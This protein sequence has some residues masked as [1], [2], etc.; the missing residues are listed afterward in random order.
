M[1]IDPVRQVFEWG[2]PEFKVLVPEFRFRIIEEAIKGEGPGIIHTLV[3]AFDVEEDNKFVERLKSL[4][5]NAGGEMLFVELQANIEVRKRRHISENRAKHKPLNVIQDDS[6][7]DAL[8]K[9][10]KLDSAGAFPY[11]EKYLRINSEEMS[12]QEAAKSIIGY[13]SLKSGGEK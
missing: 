2:S 8:D 9:G 6:Y 10:Y 13:F 3:W 4:T 7:M 11:P 5:E 1:V 12:A